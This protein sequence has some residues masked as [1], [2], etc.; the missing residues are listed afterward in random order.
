VILRCTSKLV[1]L[2]GRR[3]VQLVEVEPSDDDWY[4]NLLWLDRRKCLL[5]MHV[6]TLFPVFV[7]DVR[8]R[9]LQPLGSFMVRLIETELARERL[10]ED[11]LGRLD[12]GALRL[13]RT[14]SRSMLGF[15][16]E[17]AAECRYH[18]EAV[19]GLDR[20]DL[21]TLNRRLR[22]TLHNRDGYRDPLE[23]VAARL[24]AL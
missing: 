21:D 3:N 18:V 17:T 20:T 2:L 10:P 6:G 9:D 13:A 8:K 5:L 24:E 1:D 19:G 22:R 7:T 4:A 12:P 16:N 11:V 15:M 14:A 23:L